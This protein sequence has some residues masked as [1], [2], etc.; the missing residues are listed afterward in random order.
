M[1]SLFIR[2]VVFILCFSILSACSNVLISFPKDHIPV[3]EALKWNEKAKIKKVDIYLNDGRILKD[4]ETRIRS[5]EL[6]YVENGDYKTLD[7][8]HVKEV[9]IKP[10]ISFSFYVGLAL[11]GMAAYLFVDHIQAPRNKFGTD[12]G[13]ILVPFVVSIGGGYFVY[14]GLE[15]QTTILRFDGNQAEK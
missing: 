3:E 5:K 14:E 9:H 15:T 10:Q 11:F 6:V 2:S 12:S 8:S 4:M 1:N 7:L 13:G